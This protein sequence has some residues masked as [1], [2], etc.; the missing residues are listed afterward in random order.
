VIEILIVVG[1]VLLL[2]VFLVVGLLARRSPKAAPRPQPGVD[3][4][5]GTG[6]DAEVPRD[7]PLRNVDRV[8]A[9]LPRGAVEQP[10]P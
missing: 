2:S 10:H 6:D 8:D 4:R 1:V 3:H 5:P 9:P 7:T